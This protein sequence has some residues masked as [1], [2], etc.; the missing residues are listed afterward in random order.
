MVIAYLRPSALESAVQA[1][2]RHGGTDVAF[3]EVRGYGRQKE[4]LSA[5]RPGVLGYAFL[6][7]VRLTYAVEDRDLD[8]TLDALQSVAR[9]GSIGDGKIFVLRAVAAGESGA[10]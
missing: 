8:A 10:W 2:V 3:A 4:H 9:T 1:V 6:P 5:Y 7:R